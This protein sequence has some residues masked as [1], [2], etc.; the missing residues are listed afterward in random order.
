MNCFFLFFCWVFKKRGYCFFMFE[1]ITS[2]NY[3][4]KDI[5]DYKPNWIDSYRDIFRFFFDGSI[6]KSTLSNV[7]KVFDC[8]SNLGCMH[9][10]CNNC[11]NDHFIPFSC[12][13]RF[14]NSC[15]K[16][17]SD[18]RIS[19]LY[20]RI[21]RGISYRH[22]TFTIP[23]IL[24]WFFKRHRDALSLL[25]AAA[26]YAIQYHAALKYNWMVGVIAVI[27]TFGSKLNRNAHVHLFVTNGY[28]SFSQNR[29]IDC[30]FDFFIPYP[31]IK[32]TWTFWIL[33]RIR[34]YARRKLPY[35][36]R[37][38]ELVAVDAVWDRIIH[39]KNTTWKNFY[40][41]VNSSWPRFGFEKIVWYIWRYL[42]RPVI[43]Q[44]R[45]IDF[46]WVSVTF[47]FKDKYLNNKVSFDSC[48][49]LEFIWRL[50]QHIPNKNFHMVYYFWLFA[51]T[52]KAYFL[53]IINRAYP[54]NRFLNRPPKNFASRLMLFTG[55]NPLRCSCWGLFTK[56]AMIIPWYKPI[57]F[58]SS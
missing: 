12:K 35:D 56:Y 49:A 20:S 8:R 25:P 7:L 40:F 11:G 36:K 14:C 32:A 30:G 55:I 34:S 38:F 27:H 54:S 9:Y 28:F 41:Y 21:P 52:K 45:I 24:R 39:Y 5:F 47:S 15:S 51:P 10:K 26:F 50:I 53:P 48:S 22:F 33:K 57:F 31:S 44:S 2:Y 1:T 43:A 37:T 29:Y 3:S 6:R 17:Q 16:P 58:D 4:I 46:D 23:F 19:N 42:K 13:S 18:L